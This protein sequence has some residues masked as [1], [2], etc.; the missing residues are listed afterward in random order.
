[1][2]RR[3][4]ITGAAL[5]TN[6]LMAQANQPMDGRNKVQYNP[7]HRRDVINDALRSNTTTHDG[8]RPWTPTKF[9]I[10]KGSELASS[11]LTKAGDPRQHDFRLRQ[12][13]SPPP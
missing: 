7:C 10:I 2:R 12:F 13:L 5:G 6:V 1:M 9:L 4:Y 8:R 3:G 11:Q